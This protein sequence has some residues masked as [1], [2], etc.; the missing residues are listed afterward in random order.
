M[1]STS[2]AISELASTSEAIR[3]IP[4]GLKRKF[5]EDGEIPQ[6]KKHKR[7][8]PMP[9]IFKAK[10]QQVQKLGQGGYG[11]VFAGYRK[12]DNLPVAIKRI[13]VDTKLHLYHDGKGN[14]IPMEVAILMKLAAESEWHSAPIKLLDWYIVDPELIL[15]LE[16]PMPAVDL[17]NYIETKGG[18]LKELEAKIII[19]QLV[20]AVIDLEQKHIFHRDIKPQNLLIET[21]MTLPRVRLIDFGL[22]CFYNEGDIFSHFYG[23]H[24]PPEWH[25][26]KEYQAGPVSVFQIGLV[27]F[28]LRQKVT[29]KEG[30]SF[31]DLSK[32]HWLSKHGKDFFEACSCPDPDIRITLDQLKNHP[33]LRAMFC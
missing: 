28:F 30:M 3:F 27:L 12:V 23:T 29:Y 15:V 19:K 11:C 1:P 14:Q 20:D 9:S 21:C 25:T 16:R 33:W 17:G 13:Y 26:R 5:T 24:I 22:S 4:G 6:S 31:L 32:T 10:Y 2:K 18:Y 8:E 7:L